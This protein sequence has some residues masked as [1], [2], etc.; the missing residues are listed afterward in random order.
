M[1]LYCTYI[2]DAETKKP[3]YTTYVSSVEA[4]AQF[5]ADGFNKH[6][7]NLSIFAMVL[8]ALDRKL[9]VAPH[10]MIE[11]KA[12]GWRGKELKNGW[13]FF[14]ADMLDTPNERAVGACY[15]DRIDS[16]WLFDSA[17]DV[18]EYAKLYDGV[19]YFYYEC[20]D[21]IDDYPFVDDPVT[22][23]CVERYLTANYG[24]NHGIKP[25]YESRDGSGQEFYP[26][27]A[28]RKSVTHEDIVAVE[29]YN[30]YEGANGKALSMRCD[31]DDCGVFT[32][33][34]GEW[35]RVWGRNKDGEILVTNE[36]GFACDG[37]TVSEFRKISKKQNNASTR[38]FRID[39]VEK[40]AHRFFVE[41]KDKEEA[42]EIFQAKLNAGEI[43]FSDGELVDSDYK[44]EE[45]AC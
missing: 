34:D 25:K 15:I 6:N 32:E 20:G 9:P 42:D 3:K 43:D 24:A 29:P 26:A 5:I 18:A 11:G 45:D 21:E 35:V 7:E 27:Y 23:K 28:C 4:E 30:T 19:D 36:R 10:I 31:D 44:I 8:P 41:A 2:C 33:L 14:D 17:Y 1:K 13:G 16:M 39:L 40:L 12:D 38:Q 37:V 22:R